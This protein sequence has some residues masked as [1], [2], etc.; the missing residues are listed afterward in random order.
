MRDIFDDILILKGD[1][2]RNFNEEI[3]TKITIMIIGER[4]SKNVLKAESQMRYIKFYCDSSKKFKYLFDNKELYLFLL[5]CY[6]DDN[7]Y[8][9]FK[10]YHIND[11]KNIYDKM[12]D[13]YL[14]MFKPIEDNNDKDE[15]D[16][17]FWYP[18]S[19]PTHVIDRLEKLREEREKQEK[20][21]EKYKREK[22]EAALENMVNNCEKI[23]KIMELT[24]R[25][26]VF[27][28]LNNV[29]EAEKML[30]LGAQPDFIIE[31]NHSFALYYCME[32]KYY[33][34]AKLLVKF[35]ANVDEML[36][37]K[38]EKYV[39]EENGTPLLCY[40]FSD[41]WDKKQQDMLKFLII[42]GAD[43]D[44][45]HYCEYFIDL[46]AQGG[47]NKLLYL[48]FEQQVRVTDHSF[49]K[50]IKSNNFELLQYFIYHGARLSYKNK[51]NQN[52]L[53]IIF[54][55]LIRQTKLS[56]IK[57]SK[58][59]N[60]FKFINNNYCEHDY[61]CKNGHKYKNKHAYETHIKNK[62]ILRNVENLIEFLIKN[63]IDVNHRDKYGNTPLHYSNK[64]K[65][66]KISK[67]LHKYNA[68]L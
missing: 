64:L 60:N 34:M 25:L 21:T 42:N 54:K 29:I 22:K 26:A 56:K 19:Y 30:L 28:N 52:L 16:D 35:G 15:N 45:L 33:E 41:Y 65:I 10:N 44:C 20:N 12:I 1:V 53:T 8:N 63:N 37:D 9:K 31:D 11:I 46:C 2:F 51:E 14:L 18:E 58:P 49:K 67:I 23:R 27:I 39:Y 50:I 6:L 5:Y 55:K 61:E 47:Y 43:V 68:T 59:Y 66:N 3:L 40:H 57:D 32:N 24:K 7:S 62:N 17:S 48:A 38:F 4:M 13:R 36:V